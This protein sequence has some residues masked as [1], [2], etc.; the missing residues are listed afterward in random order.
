MDPNDSVLDQ[1]T[2]DDES[3]E[4]S[5]STPTNAAGDLG[6]VIEEDGRVRWQLLIIMTSES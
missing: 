1:V 3:L 5:S 6:L 4:G 2:F